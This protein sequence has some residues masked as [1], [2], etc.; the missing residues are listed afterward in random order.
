[1]RNQL[2][3][4]ILFLVF[5]GKINAK[6]QEPKSHVLT[7][8]KNQYS[9]PRVFVLTDAE[10]DDQCSMVRFLLYAD[11]FD[12]EGII[13]TSSQYHS[14][15]HNWAGDHWIDSYM[16]AYNDVY[17]KLKDND[18]DYPTPAYLRARAVLG[19]VSKEGA[20]TKSTPGSRLIVKTLLDEKDNR[21]IWFLA[22][23]GM[24]TL[25]RALKTIQ[26]R[27]PDKMAY[28]AQKMRFFFIWE[29]DNTYQSYIQP[30]WGKY[31]ILTIISDQFEAIAYRWDKILRPD[32]QKYFT[33]DWM[34]SHIL[35]GHGPLCSLYRAHTKGDKGGFNEGDF[36]SEGDSPSFIYTIISGLRNGDL[37]HPGWGSWGGRYTRVRGNTWL[38]PVPDST[39][40]YPEG[41]WYSQ[42]A[43]GRTYMREIYPKNQELMAEYYKPIGRWTDALQN[44]FAARADW[45]VKSYEEANHPPVVK[46]AN[47]LDISAKP[48]SKINLSA[49]GT[50]DPDG[51]ELSYTWWE[52]QNADTYHGS[53]EFQNAHQQ[54]AS[55]TVPGDASPG[56]T[57]H[58]VCEVKDNGSPQ[59]TR[60]KR[61]VVRVK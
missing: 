14:H 15:G 46:L 40:Q 17:P 53:I 9:K 39:Y 26:E 5:T 1:M 12:I 22:W 55:F 21:P 29:Q 24:N 45:C 31:N 61:V 35:K 41:R 36:R 10:I 33:G 52:Y 58:V 16:N 48:G 56:E 28:V 59:L 11:V 49:K 8:T 25:A 27:H 37:E 7:N 60:Y 47:A 19:N 51:D 3:F 54:D 38:D 44:D 43:W 23:G 13:T 18:P 4:F 2:I 42:T 34:K 57:I 30:D 50:T 6:D 20:M 32:K